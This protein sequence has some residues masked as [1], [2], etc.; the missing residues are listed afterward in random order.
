MGLMTTTPAELLA[1]MDEC[2]YA[3]H[4]LDGRRATIAGMEE[5]VF[6]KR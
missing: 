4:H 3:A 1:F 5:L 6:T 2:G